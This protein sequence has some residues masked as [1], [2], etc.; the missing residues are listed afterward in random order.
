MFGK[1]IAG[2]SF[3]VTVNEVSTEESL[4]VLAGLYA[5]EWLKQ[6]EGEGEDVILE[7][8]KEDALIE[9][10]VQSAASVMLTQRDEPFFMIDECFGQILNDRRIMYEAF[11]L[12]IS[13]GQ[14]VELNAQFIKNTS[15]NYGAS[16]KGENYY[17]LATKLGSNI[18]FA[19]VSAGIKNDE[20]VTIADNNFG[21][22]QKDGVRE[23]ELNLKENCYYMKVYRKK[24]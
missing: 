13:A 9:L 12:T 1:L 24:Q 7:H 5:K 3:A 2:A 10:M 14:S 23:V 15:L 11:D 21:F 4:S 17:D 6:Y 18:E 22:D 19:K 16:R 20:F 8:I